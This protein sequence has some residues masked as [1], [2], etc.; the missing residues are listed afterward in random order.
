MVTQGRVS[1][2]ELEQFYNTTEQARLVP[3]WL[4]RARQLRPSPVPFLWRWADVEPLVHRS[5][6]VVT[7]DRDVERR[8]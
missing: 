5:G 6:E 8:V 2:E 4:G 3:G 1:P 7:P